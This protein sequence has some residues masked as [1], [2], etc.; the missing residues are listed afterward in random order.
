LLSEQLEQRSVLQPLE[1][2]FH[3]LQSALLKTLELLETEPLVAPQ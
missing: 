3:C 2:W 1:T